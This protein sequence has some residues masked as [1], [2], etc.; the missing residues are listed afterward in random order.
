M[1]T[2]PMSVAPPVTNRALVLEVPYMQKFQGLWK[3]LRCHGNGTRWERGWGKHG[4]VCG[5]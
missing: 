4:Q 1:E 5:V 2:G 3:Q